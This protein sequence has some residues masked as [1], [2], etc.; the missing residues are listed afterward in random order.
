MTQEE[1]SKAYDEAFERASITHKNGDSHLKATLER[2]FPE[3]QE[4]DDEK[5]KQVLIDLVKCNERSGYLVLNNVSTDSMI[6]WLEK[7]SEQKPT[8]P[9]WSEEDERL[10]QCLAED[11]EE[12]LN[13]VKNSKYGHSEII[14][15]LKEM[16]EERIDWLK[17]L[18]ERV[19]PQPKREWSEED[20]ETMSLAIDILGYFERHCKE[21]SHPSDDI[22][23]V[24]SWLESL[25]ERLK[26][27]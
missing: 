14:S 12:A 3:L 2:I 7:Q 16:Y 25:K 18:K 22:E 17:S 4:G 10:L 15:D 13:K 21:L 1:K 5:I 19:Q 24:I 27:E 11:Q 23:K 6:S 9:T 20:I 8:L 26:G